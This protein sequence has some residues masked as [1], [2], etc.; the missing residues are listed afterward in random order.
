[1]TEL[2]FTVVDIVARAVRR[3]AAA[4]RPAAGRGDQRRA[5]STRIALR[6]PGA[7][8][9]AAPPL[10]RRRG[11]RAARPVRRP[12][13]VAPRPSGRSSG[14]SAS[15]HG[16]RASPA[17][18]EVDL[19]LPCTYDFEV[20]GVQVPARPARRRD[21]AAPP[22]QR[23]RLHPRRDRLRRRAGAVGPRGRYRLPVPVWRDLME[24]HFPD[25]GWL[26]LRRDTLAALAPLPG[27]PRADHLGR[28][29]RAAARRSAA[30][31]RES[32]PMT[33]RAWPAPSP[34][35]SSTRA[36]CSTP[37]GRRRGKNQVRW[38]F[39][40]LGPPGAAAAGLGRGAA[41]WPPSACS[42]AG[43]ERRGRPCTCASCSCSAGWPRRATTAAGSRRSRELARRRADRWLTLGRGRRARGRRCGRSRWPSCA[44]AAGA[45]PVE[46]AGRPGR[47]GARRRRGRPIAGGWCAGVGPSAAVRCRL[48][49]DA[50]DDGGRRCGCTSPSTNTAARTARTADKQ[51]AIARVV[52]RH[53]PAAGR[54]GRGVR[55]ADRPAA[56]RGRSRGRGLR[57]APLL[58]GAGR[59][60]RARR[61]VLLVSPIILY[62]HPAVAAGEPVALFDSTEI[63]EILT[64]RV[65]TLTDEEKAEA[66]ATDPRAAAIIDRCDA[67]SAGGTAA[68]ARR[69]ARPARPRPSPALTAGPAAGSGRQQ[70]IRADVPWWDPA[71][72]ASVHPTTDAVLIGRRPGGPGQPGPAASE[73]AG[74][75]PGPVLRRP[76]GP[77]HRRALRRRR[78]HPRRPGPRGRPGGR[79]ARLVRP[80]PLLRAGRTGAAGTGPSGGPA[81]N[82]HGRESPDH[83]SR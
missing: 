75:R 62:D 7:D 22:V 8:R 21:P 15:H 68:A 5:V 9:A 80:L 27:R 69:P 61:D 56:G 58:A 42:A 40:V 26:R 52:H 30:T 50:G 28:R 36:T 29:R 70:R 83:E 63:D 78:Q 23:H 82:P 54:A 18:T 14:C 66:R 25:T 76:G 60:R 6:V 1:M 65:L 44:A 45:L 34:T 46:V 4:D 13:P 72:D 10:R 59:R 67:M 47:R 53:P 39:G 16:R 77:G 11:A 35:P 2:S 20:A 71:A 37:T 81:R 55:L 51:D 32:G 64:L 73:P 3:G 41:T 33:P 12:R 19:P 79:P 17:S 48:T 38:Q 31:V 49:A 57:P 74:R 24:P 43:G